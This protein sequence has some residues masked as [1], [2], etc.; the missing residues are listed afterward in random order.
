MKNIIIII[1]LLITACGTPSQVG[2]NGKYK[3]SKTSLIAQYTLKSSQFVVGN[4]DND[5]SIYK[6]T[7]E[8]SNGNVFYSYY[9]VNI[10]IVQDGQ[11]IEKLSFI[12]DGSTV[13]IDEK[14]SITG[15]F[16][17]TKLTIQYF[18]KITTSLKKMNWHSQTTTFTPTNGSLNAHTII[19]KF[20]S[21][22]VASEYVE[23]YKKI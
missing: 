4:Y 17:G 12:A 6:V 21:E 7:A 9:F 22:E 23:V 20:G 11:A 5:L 14:K 16:D 3:N 13:N 15:N 10:S 1:S 8:D 2:E 19:Y 18:E